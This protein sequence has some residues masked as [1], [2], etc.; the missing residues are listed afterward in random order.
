M[1]AR[2]AVARGA[3]DLVELTALREDIAIARGYRV[4]VV[5]GYSRMEIKWKPFN[6]FK[7]VRRILG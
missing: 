6:Y 2:S 7:G 1:F 5:E 3:K 4:F